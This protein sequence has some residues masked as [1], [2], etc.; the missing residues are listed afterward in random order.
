MLKL[1]F[2][3]ST[4][5]LF[6]KLLALE[7]TQYAKAVL[8]DADILVQHDKRPPVQRR[9]HRFQLLLLRTMLSK[10]LEHQKGSEPL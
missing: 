4:C 10:H 6:T 3:L 5:W 8:L 9:R 7:L 2:I 1:R